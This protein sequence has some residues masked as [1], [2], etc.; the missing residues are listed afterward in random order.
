MIRVSTKRILS[1][2]LSA[3]FL[4]AAVVIYSTLIRSEIKVIDEKRTIV[5]SKTVLFNNQQ[6]AVNQVSELI[7][8]YKGV[9]K[10]QQTVS[11]A[12]PASENTIGALRQIEAIGRA[13]GVQITSLSFTTSISKSK[14]K[15]FTKKLGVLSISIRAEDSYETLKNFLQLLETTVRV[16]NV[17]T[18]KF[19][20]GIPQPGSR[21]PVPNDTL[22]IMVEMYYQE[23]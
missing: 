3:L 4:I 6:N 17:K 13:S 21:A 23:S 15:S 8:K 12:V 7:S 14:I 16:A 10:L 22:N 19:Q 1:I 2:G 11:L 5:A 20:P 18:F 9:A